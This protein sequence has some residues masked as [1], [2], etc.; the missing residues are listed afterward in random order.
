MLGLGP[1]GLGQRQRQDPVLECR[2][3]LLGVDRPWQRD[4]ADVLAR[5]SLVEE[6]CRTFGKDGLLVLGT[7]GQHTTLELDVDA[8][9]RGAGDEGADDEIVGRLID[10]HREIA[11]AHRRPGEPATGAD[12]SIVQQ[13]VHA[14]SHGYEVAQR[15]EAIPDH[16]ECTSCTGYLELARHLT[17][18]AP[19]ITL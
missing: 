9:G 6:P 18:R 4:L 11:R 19:C 3:C 2:L 17:C 12:P 5:G 14:V 8:I 15:A 10:V 7:Q 16:L 13:A 1:G